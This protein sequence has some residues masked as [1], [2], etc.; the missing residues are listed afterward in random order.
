[1]PTAIRG[2]AGSFTDNPEYTL[3]ARAPKDKSEGS[4]GTVYGGHTSGGGN[5][6]GPE[7]PNQQPTPHPDLDSR[8]VSDSVSDPATGTDPEVIVLAIIGAFLIFLL[9]GYS[10]RM[11]MHRDPTS[12]KKDH[13]NRMKGELEDMEAQNDDVEFRSF[14]LAALDSSRFS[15][16]VPFPNRNIQTLVW[17]PRTTS[18]PHCRFDHKYLVNGPAARRETAVNLLRVKLR[19]RNI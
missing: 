8:V 18:S 13:G 5:Y 2:N 7:N 17:G 6:T 4:T 15:D 19:L 1:M 12:R 3:K 16:S 14:F 9:L 10:L 11:Y